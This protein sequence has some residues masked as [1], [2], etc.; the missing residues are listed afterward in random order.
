MKT[1]F[2]T[3]VFAFFLL[4][5]G[6]VSETQQ[7]AGKGKLE[8]TVSYERQSGSGS[9]QYAI[10]IENA[11]GELV[12]TIFVTKFTAQGGYSF[13][14]DCTPTW[15]N[16]ANPA[17]KSE[18]EIDA[19]SGATPQTGNHTYTWNLTDDKGNKVTT[20]EYTFYVEGTYL[21]KGK[22]LFKSVISVGDK[23]ISVEP[24]PEFSSDETKNKG[25]ITSVKA[26]Y[27]P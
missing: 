2:L 24:Q 4:G 27:L 5:A 3:L 15:V 8:I 18:Q 21:G 6:S 22:V 26:T 13:R 20:G 23:T 19:F 17:S 11:Q 12:K 1:T 7:A 9:N 14:P 10:W 25:M 16:K